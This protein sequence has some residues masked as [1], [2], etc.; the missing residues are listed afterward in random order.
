M[1]EVSLLAMSILCLLST[2]VATGPKA[3]QTMYTEGIF[4][5]DIPSDF[6]RVTGSKLEEFRNMWVGGARDLADE[7]GLADPNY[8]TKIKLSFFSIFQ[9]SNGKLTIA[10]MG[11]SVPDTMNLDE[12]LKTNTD[13]TRWGIEAGHLS[14]SSKGVSKLMIDSV[15]CLLMDIES[16]AGSRLLTYSFFL[17]K[18]PKYSFA[19]GI[20][21]DD[22]ATY[23]KDQNVIVAIVKSIRITRAVR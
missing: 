21:C 16:A 10:F 20:A 13:R 5:V 4:Q 9:K 3:I 6:T 8:L 23:E 7:S 1:K 2:S 12:M 19:L 17:P 18:H 15:S 22:K 14:R 11:M